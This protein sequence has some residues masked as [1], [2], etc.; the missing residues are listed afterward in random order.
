M[1]DNIFQTQEKKEELNDGESIQAEQPEKP[2]KKK[3][4]F[5]VRF[6]VG[7]LY[8]TILI[9]FFL[10][11]IFVN[12][13]LFDFIVLGFSVLGTYEMIRAF[14]GKITRAQAFRGCLGTGELYAAHHARRVHCGACRYFGAARHGAPAD[15]SRIHGL[16]AHRVRLSHGVFADPCRL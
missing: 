3:S 2:R 10:L 7:T 8:M 6:G 11:K 4:D 14:R 9:G 15:L 5:W 12:D 13:F 16:C 1:E